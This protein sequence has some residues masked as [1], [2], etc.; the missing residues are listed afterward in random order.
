VPKQRPGL[1]AP[2]IKEVGIKFADLGFYVS[3]DDV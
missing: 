1:G 3:F 2:W